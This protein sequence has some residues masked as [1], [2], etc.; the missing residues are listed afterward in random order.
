MSTRSRSL[1]I[2]QSP[3]GFNQFGE[4]RLGDERRKPVAVNAQTGAVSI[5][6][7]A[8]FAAAMAKLPPKPHR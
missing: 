8:L 3:N 6:L 5:G 7:T 1:G 2:D 4:P